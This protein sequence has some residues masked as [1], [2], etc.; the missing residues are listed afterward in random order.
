MRDLHV[1]QHV[2][3]ASLGRQNVVNRRL[4]VVVAGG[5]GVNRE[6]AE[7]TLR[8]VEFDKLMPMEPAGMPTLPAPTRS[9]PTA[10]STV[11][12]TSI[13]D[14]EHA[15]A[16]DAGTHPGSAPGLGSSLAASIASLLVTVA[17]LAEQ[18]PARTRPPRH[19]ARSLAALT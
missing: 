15:V 8:A 6:A 17:G 19:S 7:L 3:A 18:L 10:F 1:L 12:H 2:L 4:E 14:L 13:L 5:L 11:P 9:P 16:L